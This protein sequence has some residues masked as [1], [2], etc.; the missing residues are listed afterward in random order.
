MDRSWQP[1]VVC[2]AEHRDD[3][4]TYFCPR[5]K[6][7][8]TG[9]I[10]LQKRLLHICTGEK[11]AQEILEALAPDFGHKNV[12]LLL[13]ALKDANVVVDAT[14]QMWR[15]Y[16]SFTCN[17]LPF[18]KLLSRDEAEELFWQ[19]RA[20]ADSKEVTIKIGMPD[21]KLASLLSRRQ[22]NRIF[23]GLS[24]L[25]NQVTNALW[26]GYGQ[27]TSLISRDTGEELFRRTVPSAGGL[28]PLQ[29]HLVMRVACGSIRPGIYRMHHDAL[30]LGEVEVWKDDDKK[31]SFEDCFLDDDYVQTCAA[32]IVISAEIDR[33]AK[34]YGDR[35]YRFAIL[36]AG[37][38]AQNVLLFC[39]E[40][41]IG[42]VEVGGFWDEELKQLLG[43]KGETV[44]LTTIFLGHV[45][46]RRES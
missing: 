5:E 3:T 34:K 35:A 37:H 2:F 4:M 27:T 21:T 9:E 46:T 29:L 12:E 13:L 11:S 39:T 45:H 22:S 28:Y 18:G 10:E 8:I 14:S 44:P 1:R 25:E 41:Q 43:L 42:C 33:Q 15:G 16:H 6:L 38:A 36:E 17:P 26:A 7:V 30:A 20:S 40:N 32:C 19:R 31:K 23:S 24:L